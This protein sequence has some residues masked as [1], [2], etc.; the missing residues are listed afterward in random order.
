VQFGGVGVESEPP[1]EECIQDILDFIEAAVD[2]GD[3]SGS[4]PGNSANNRLDTMINMI[5][6]CGDLIEEG[7]YGQAYDQ[8]VTV[9]AKCDGE[10]PPP[11]F[12]EG[13]ARVELAGMISDLLTILELLMG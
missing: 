11:D 12:V 13:P 9:Y 5:E 10:S 8:L 3:L 4:G 6:A 2:E 7:Y 1:P